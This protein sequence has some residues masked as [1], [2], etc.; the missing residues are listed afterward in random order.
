MT[1]R[2]A[3]FDITYF[4]Y[5]NSINKFPIDYIRFDSMVPIPTG[6]GT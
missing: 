5:L 3:S 6:S 4:D 1:P 2:S